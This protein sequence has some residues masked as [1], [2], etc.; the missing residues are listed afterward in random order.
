MKEYKEY[1]ENE[2][3]VI[4]RQ[5]EQD[6]QINIKLEQS[7]EIEVKQYKEFAAQ[8]EYNKQ[9]LTAINTR[10]SE[11]IK[12]LAQLEDT[13]EDL[14]FK[15]GEQIDQM[16]IE[17]DELR[18]ENDIYASEVDYFERVQKVRLDSEI[19]A[20]RSLLNSQAKFQNLSASSSIP[21]ITTGNHSKHHNTTSVNEL[22]KLPIE[23]YQNNKN[24]TFISNTNTHSSVINNNTNTNTHFSSS[25]Q[26]PPSPV[27]IPQ[28]ESL[29]K[30]SNSK[31]ETK[32]NNST[33][34]GNTSNKPPSPVNLTTANTNVK[35]S[36]GGNGDVMYDS[37]SKQ[38]GGSNGS[39]QKPLSSSPLNL[40]SSSNNQ[41][42][43]S[44]SF[45]TNEYT[46]HYASSSV[47]RGPNN[48][49][50]KIY[51]SDKSGV[52]Q[53]SSDKIGGKKRNF[54]RYVIN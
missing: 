51:H 16:Q 28:N 21:T 10:N 44:N 25:T 11:L 6:K 24:T 47:V 20:Y 38:H 52:D 48:N 2:L 7:R 26:K 36:S 54:F 40:P 23:Y 3:N 22:T 8:L 9:E 39:Q 33:S 19:Q 1:K 13:Y 27:N 49:E 4:Q 35:I 5:L 29:I 31:Y 41:N 42:V 46:Q 37:S 12:I 34:Y 14:R 18:S 50:E 53:T 43:V 30:E 15:N 32:T 17:I 45:S